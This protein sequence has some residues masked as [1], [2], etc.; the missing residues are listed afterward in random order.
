MSFL[1]LSLPRLIMRRLKFM[2]WYAVTNKFQML[3]RQ[4]FPLPSLP[5]CFLAEPYRVD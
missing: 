2:S 5:L 1:I 4:L 3:I